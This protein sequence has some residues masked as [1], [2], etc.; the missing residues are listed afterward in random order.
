MTNRASD[1][2][3]PRVVVEGR[4]QAGK[5]DASRWL[6][7]FNAVYSRK[8][9]VPVFPGSLN[10]ALGGH[11]DWFAP[12]LQPHVL[13]FDREE[14][15]GERDILLLPCT[16]RSLRGQRAFLWSPTTAARGRPDPRVVL[17]GGDPLDTVLDDFPDVT[18]EYAAAVL[19][20]ARAAQDAYAAE[21]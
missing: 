1:S 7:R 2:A 10:A 3:P 21:A 18:R 6:S 4:V 11:F 9:G 14:Y 5:G 19:E 15:G 17:E 16:L 20:L 8:L 13:W 12:W